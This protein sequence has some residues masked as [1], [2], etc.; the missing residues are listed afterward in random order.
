MKVAVLGAGHG[1]L[2]AAADL[3][4]RGHEVRLTTRSPQ[5]LAPVVERGGIE[6]EGAAGKGFAEVALVTTDLR[7]AVEGADLVMLVVP[8]TA[9][10][11]YARELAAVLGDGQSVFLNPGH[12]CGGLH[13]VTELQRAGYEGEPRTC[14]ASTL[15]YGCRVKG[16]AHV[17]VMTVVPQLPFAAFPGKHGAALCEQV[18][19]LFPAIKL[20][21]NVLETA[22]LNINA[23]EH[24]PMTLL[25]AGWIEYT[26]GNFYIYYEGTSPAVGARSQSGSV[27]L[28]MERNS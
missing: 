20:A 3:T 28:I 9:H 1:G 11:H 2:T 21:K 13:F 15:T 19:E 25:N 27:S 10:A 12:T 14:E 18:R 23:I 16:P 6:L 26:E 24:P 22:F 8:V 17:N 5:T 7:E 4:L